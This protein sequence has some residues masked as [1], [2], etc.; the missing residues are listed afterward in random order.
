MRKVAFEDK[1]ND[2]ISLWNREFENYP[3]S[4]RLV[5]EKLINHKDVKD[6]YAY[7]ND[8][9][10]YVASIVLKKC[11][12]GDVLTGYI[13]FV[14]VNKKYR[15]QGIGTKMIKDAIEFFQTQDVPAIWLGCDYGCL[16]SGL[17]IDNNEECH[18]FFLNR[19]FVFDHNTHNII[20]THKIETKK[21]LSDEYTY[22]FLDKRLKEEFFEFVSNGFSRRWANENL[23]TDLN[24]IMIILKDGKIVAFSRICMKDSKTLTNGINNYLRY[25]R[26]GITLGALGPL[27]VSK[28]LRKT[29]LGREIVLYGVS[30]LF[31][32][33]ADQI[34]VDWTSLIN[35]YKKVCFEEICDVYSQYRYDFN[36]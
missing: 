30:E 28:D 2:I 22:Q 1:M 15:K 34:L 18:K 8:N 17:F 19:G 4:E 36:K 25:E 31:K 3:L 5:L 23:E 7:I 32:R 16:Y 11:L 13:S 35:F 21:S 26:Q 12:K 9:G 29:G 14:H 20:L 6:A 10:E 24:E 33:G 27:G